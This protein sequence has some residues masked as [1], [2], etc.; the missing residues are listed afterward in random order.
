MSVKPHPVKKAGGFRLVFR[1]FIISEEA[2]NFHGNFNELSRK[3]QNNFPVRVPH[4]QLSGRKLSR[5][6]PS[7]MGCR[8]SRPLP[9]GCK[10]SRLQPSALKARPASAECFASSAD[11]SRVDSTRSPEWIASPADQA[12]QISGSAGFSRVAC[13]LSRLQLSV[14]QAQPTK[15]GE[16]LKLSL[17]CSRELGLIR[18][19]GL[20][21]MKFHGK[22]FYFGEFHG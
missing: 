7:I 15:H 14:M 12:K 19:L 17:S 4:H 8:L 2:I 6:Q 13:K 1:N 11:L 3:F 16:T 22:L 21:V 18:A 9:G 20:A 5:H 10:L